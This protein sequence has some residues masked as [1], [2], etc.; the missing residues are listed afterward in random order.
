MEFCPI[1]DRILP[2]DG[3][4]VDEHH[5]IPKMYGGKRTDDNMIRLH[6]V[7]HR[8]I[9]SVFTEKQLYAHYHTVFR[10]VNHPEMQKFIRWVAK[11]SPEFY[12]V[13]KD[14]RIKRSYAR[15]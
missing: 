14:H 13:S 7:C 3:T 6:R 8:K 15:R 11:K 2:P 4:N 5:L 12:C 1:C 9:H 10:I